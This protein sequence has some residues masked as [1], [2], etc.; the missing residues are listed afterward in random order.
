MSTF[1]DGIKKGAGVAIGAGLVVGA[2]GLVVGGPAG[3]WAGFKLGMGAGALG[4]GGS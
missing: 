1:T 3:A 2:F 4:S